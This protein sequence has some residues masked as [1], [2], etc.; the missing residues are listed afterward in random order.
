LAWV[1]KMPASSSIKYRL[2]D[3]KNQAQSPERSKDLHNFAEGRLACSPDL[4]T[5]NHLF[6]Y[7]RHAKSF[8]GAEYKWRDQKLRALRFNYCG[9]QV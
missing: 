1:P 8:D 9:R 4:G 2:L 6:P 3:C 7:G 5:R